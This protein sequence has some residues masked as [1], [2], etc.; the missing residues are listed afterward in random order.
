[1]NDVPTDVSV[2]QNGDST[3][4]CTL[5]LVDFFDG[6]EFEGVGKEPDFV[7]A[8]NAKGSWALQGD[9]KVDLTAADIE[10]IGNAINNDFLSR[11]Q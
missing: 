8:K 9:S 11:N 2:Q 10:N 5:N 7:L 3:Y 6:G 4:N 1:M